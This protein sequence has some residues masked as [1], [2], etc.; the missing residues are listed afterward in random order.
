MT[1][2][3]AMTPPELS[4]EATVNEPCRRT[5]RK[6]GAHHKGDVISDFPRFLGPASEVSELA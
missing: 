5:A 3:T 2:G 6:A 4:N 1:W